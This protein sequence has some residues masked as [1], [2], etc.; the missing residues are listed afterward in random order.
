[1]AGGGVL[2]VARLSLLGLQG[3]RGVH[4]FWGD[5]GMESPAGPGTLRNRA[6]T[7]RSSE[8]LGCAPPSPGPHG[9]GGDAL[10]WWQV[11]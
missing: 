6:G 1:M 11:C 5:E 8:H 7:G 2:G 10:A 9:G 3:A 4:S